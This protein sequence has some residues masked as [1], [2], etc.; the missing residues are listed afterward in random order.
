MP[1]LLYE[2]NDSCDAITSLMYS[3]RQES[4]FRKSVC[5]FQEGVGLR[6]VVVSTK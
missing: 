4:R 1:F 5:S 3:I 6:E 2:K